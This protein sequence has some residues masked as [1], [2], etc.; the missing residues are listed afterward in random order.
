MSFQQVSIIDPESPMNEKA[1]QPGS[2]W[3]KALVPL[4]VLFVAG[5]FIPLSEK[6]HSP[7]Y[8]DVNI[9]ETL[10]NQ[11]SQ[12]VEAGLELDQLNKF[13]ENPNAEVLVGRSLYPRSYKQGEGEISFYFYPFTIMDFPRSGFFLIGSGGQNNIVLAGEEHKYLPHAVDT[14]VIGCREQ[15]YVDALMV[16]VLD[17]NNTVY[18]RSPISELSC[19][20]KQPL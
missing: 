7:R 19:P 14:L 2:F 6:L 1:S 9:Q 5:S 12:I 20:M 17:D 13:L 16:I 3:R 4:I 15:N 8:A 18:T 10:Q 11:E